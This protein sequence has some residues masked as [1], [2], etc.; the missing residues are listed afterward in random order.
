MYEYQNTSSFGKLYLLPKI[1]QK[2]SRHPWKTVYFKLWSTY[3]KSIR[4]L[5]NQLKS[6][7][8]NS[9]SY[10]RDFGRFY[11]LLLASRTY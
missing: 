7:M 3:W 10:I 9:K 2:N 5:E 1:Y 6:F 8:K 4:V 11:S